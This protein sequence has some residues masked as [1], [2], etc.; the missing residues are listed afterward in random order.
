MLKKIQNCGHFIPMEQP[1]KLA[2]IVIDFVD[3]PK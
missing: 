3:N 2:E 1:E